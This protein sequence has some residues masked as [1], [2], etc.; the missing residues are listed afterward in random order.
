MPTTTYTPLAN[1]TLSAAA[2]TVTFSSITTSTYRDLVLVSQVTGAGANVDLRLNSD[3]TAT[4]Y[5]WARINGNG[6]TGASST[7]SNRTVVNGLVGNSGTIM[8]FNFFD[9]ETTDKHKPI[10]IRADRADTAT[11]LTSVRWANTAAITSIM[12]ENASTGFA[13]GSTFALYGIAG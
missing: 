1:L 5:I 2:A 10:L 9:W 11:Q 3:T 4:N 13:A 7:G 6:A 8:T 12:L